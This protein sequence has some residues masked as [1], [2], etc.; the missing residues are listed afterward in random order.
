MIASAYGS[1]ADFLQSAYAPRKFLSEQTVAKYE[2]T[3]RHYGRFLGRSAEIADLDE[4]RIAEFLSDF[5]R[6][7]QSWTVVTARK[8]LQALGTY[9]HRKGL[10]NDAPDVVRVPLHERLPQAYTIDEIGRL[11]QA[12]RHV[13]GMFSG[14]PGRLFFPAL[15]LVAYDTGGRSGAIWQLE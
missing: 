3:L 1:L 8:H 15:F 13:Q 14:V 6:D 4:D 5:R 2:I 12:A 11:V 10:L 9:A 7:H